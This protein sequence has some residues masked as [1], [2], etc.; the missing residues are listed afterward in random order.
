MPYG[1]SA[2]K[3]L[4]ITMQKIRIGILGAADIAYRRFLPALRK[5]ENFIFAGVAVA[6]ESGKA[7]AQRIADEFGGRIY[8]G[9]ENLLRERDIDA[10]Y[11]PLPPSLHYT[12]ADRAL[13]MGKH[14]L[15]EKPCTMSL[16]D[17]EALV[18][19]AEEKQL[20]LNENY[21]FTMQRQI[22][23][24]RELISSGEIGQLRLIRSAFGFPY[25]SADDFRYHREM[26][27]GALLDC[28]GY[29]IKVAQL[30]LDEDIRVLTSALHRTEKHDVD[31]YG[32]VVLADR[33]QT[34]TQLAFG[35]DNAYRCELEI[36]GSKACIYAPRIF[37]PP[38]EL[39][40]RIVVK[41]QTE[42]TISVEPDD[43]FMHVIEYFGACMEDREMR[44]Q[45][46]E[47]IAAQARLIE[48][49]REMDVCRSER[50]E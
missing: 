3:G 45:A 34:E 18:R 15:S 41:G 42:K 13:N 16:R 5:T 1:G 25:R 6:S 36:W 30:F 2:W 35:M 39:E 38:A 14:V 22:R 27:G 11:I 19:L 33:N 47:G 8:V 7:R 48:A 44:E 21:A 17:A 9:Y 31:M 4:W 12:W 10:V 26:G 43:Q 50:K 29:V 20:V 23:M 24:I 40:A 37:T 46:R 32:S 28:G 49:V